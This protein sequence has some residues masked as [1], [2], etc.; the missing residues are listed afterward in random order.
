[1]TRSALVTTGEPTLHAALELSKNS[2]LLAIQFP[3]RDAPSLYPLRGGDADG[4]MAKLDAARDRVAKITGRMP[5]VT[6]C[7]EAGYDGFWLARF[8][9]H[10]GIDCLVME[11]AS[12]QVDRR[13]RRV[14][15][16]RIDVE[17]LLHAL[18]AWRRGERHVCS[19][20]VI[21]SVEEEDVRRSHRERDRLVRERTAHINRIKGL[22]FG[23][24]IRGINVKKHY[25]TLAA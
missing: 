1:M 9:E 17:G 8:L 10:H 7:Y 22:L 16:D 4:L 3:E 2:W 19:M 12:L 18:I 13:A 25:K 11:P 14:K 15:T 21:P 5:A 6:L 23:Q 20:V 24:G